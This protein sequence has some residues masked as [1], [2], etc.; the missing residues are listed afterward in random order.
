MNVCEGPISPP[1]HLR[2][3]GKGNDGTETQQKTG[4]GVFYV[5]GECVSHLQALAGSSQTACSQKQESNIKFTETNKVC[6]VCQ[7]GRLCGDF[8]A[9][10]LHSDFTPANHSSQRQRRS[11]AVV[12]SDPPP[13][14]TR[15]RLPQMGLIFWFWPPLMVL[16]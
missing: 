1:G 11:T 5:D 6:Y 9:P 2:S 7:G 8:T 15:A 4:R 12:L 14:T 13:P 10:Q 16:A 3:V